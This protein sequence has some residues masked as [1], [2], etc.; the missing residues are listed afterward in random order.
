MESVK[1]G[2][3]G[4][5]KYLSNWKNL[6]NHAVVGVF[7]LL[8]AIYAPIN[9]LIKLGIIVIVITL[10]VSRMKKDK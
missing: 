3:M 9:I 8:V 5:V 1:K 4:I 10:N 7:F 2:L 6:L